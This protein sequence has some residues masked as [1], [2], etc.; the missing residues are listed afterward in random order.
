MGSFKFSKMEL[1]DTVCIVRP[2]LM[3]GSLRA[4]LSPSMGSFKPSKIELGDKVSNSC[5]GQLRTGPPWATVLN[6]YL[7]SASENWWGESLHQ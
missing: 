5:K 1:G 3:S 2:Y 6:I 7:L 4:S